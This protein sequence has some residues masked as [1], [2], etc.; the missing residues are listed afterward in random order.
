MLELAVYRF[1]TIDMWNYCAENLSVGYDGEALVRD[2][3]FRVNAGECILLCG[4]NGTGK[5]T[6]LRTV[7][8]MLQPVAGRCGFSGEGRVFL[9]PARIPKV[10]GFSVEE[11]IATSCGKDTDWLGRMSARMRDRVKAALSS[12]GILHLAERDI[13]TL[14]D[15]EFQKASVCVALVRNADF[16]LLDEPTAFLDVDNK[17]DVMRLLRDIT[18]SGEVSVLLSSHDIDVAARHCSRVFGIAGESFIDASA[19]D[20]DIVFGRCFASRRGL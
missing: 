4:A 18:A 13:S 15:G 14:S 10:G 11:F 1:V 6:M 8:G 20:A 12:I 9:V 3:G 17:E 19:A 7:A 2:I 5:S 16:I